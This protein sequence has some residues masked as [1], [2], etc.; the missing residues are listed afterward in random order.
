M[1]KKLLK[2][3][4]TRY[5]IAI[6][7]S[8]IGGLIKF[9]L[10]KSFVDEQANISHWVPIV[11]ILVVSC[12]QYVFLRLIYKELF[13]TNYYCEVKELPRGKIVFSFLLIGCVFSIILNTILFRDSQIY[14]ILLRSEGGVLPFFIY[15][16]ILSLRN[17]KNTKRNYKSILANYS[18][19]FLL[20]NAIVRPDRSNFLLL[21]GILFLVSLYLGL[22]LK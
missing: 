19:F 8:M 7:V 16:H 10:A 6:I 4:K 18:I 11:V 9:L 15:W 3:S 14:D 13:F 1:N 20:V 17:M 22:G 12:C 2:Y 5:S 21:Y